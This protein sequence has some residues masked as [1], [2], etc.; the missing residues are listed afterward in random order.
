MDFR[1]D[2]HKL[3]QTMHNLSVT[4]LA[5]VC[6][7]NSRDPDIQALE[8]VMFNL[9]EYL[10]KKME[11]PISNVGGA[12]KPEMSSV[13]GNL[14]STQKACK[15]DRCCYKKEEVDFSRKES[16]KAAACSASRGKRISVGNASTE[17]S[18]ESVC[19]HMADTV[20]KGS[21]SMEFYQSGQVKHSEMMHGEL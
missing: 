4:L 3:V 13:T 19:S 17:I 12:S 1:K 9:S 2:C 14:K 16:T 7:N 11:L 8:S 10:V 21:T 6:T 5:S 20:E 18:A 15:S